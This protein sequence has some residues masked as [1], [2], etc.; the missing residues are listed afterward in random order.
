MSESQPPSSPPP[1]LTWP[2]Y[3]LAAVVLF[4]TLCIIWTVREANRLK[5]AKQDGMSVPR[6]TQRTNWGPGQ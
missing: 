1:K 6:A 5:R 4:F 3:A 2:K